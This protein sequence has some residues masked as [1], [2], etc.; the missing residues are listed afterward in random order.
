D[1]TFRDAYTSQAV[2]AGVTPV[3]VTLDGS[4]VP[5][6]AGVPS[7][8]AY[9][10]NGVAVAIAGKS[11]MPVVLT[12]AIRGGVLGNEVTDYRLQ[13]TVL[14]ASGAVVPNTFP[15]SIQDPAVGGWTPIQE[16]TLGQTSRAFPLDHFLK[17]HL[18]QVGLRLNV[19]DINSSTGL[20][21]LRMKLDV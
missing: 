8:T 20:D 12:Q 16:L 10:Q 18:S 15:V 21:S 9:R 5:Y 6:G 7:P 4:G 2:T 14:S 19:L 13:V 1:Y 17:D 3:V 11:G